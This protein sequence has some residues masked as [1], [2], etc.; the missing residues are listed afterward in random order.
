MALR[1]FGF[2]TGR[3]HAHLRYRRTHHTLQ[4][5]CRIC[6]NVKSTTTLFDVHFKVCEF[7][8]LARIGELVQQGQLDDLP[9]PLCL[10]GKLPTNAKMGAVIQNLE[11][12]T[13]NV[14]KV[15]HFTDKVSVAHV[16]KLC[17]GNAYVPVFRQDRMT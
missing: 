16:S 10:G 7:G 9:L 17:T 2:A 15:I 13:M 12:G 4:A 1:I 5:A 6:D 11:D 8:G 3:P 14:V